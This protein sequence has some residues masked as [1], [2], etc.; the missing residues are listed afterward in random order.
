SNRRRVAVRVLHKDFDTYEDYNVLADG[1]DASAPLEV[2]LTRSER[3]LGDVLDAA[4]EPV[5]G[6]RIVIETGAP[7]PAAQGWDPAAGIE[8]FSGDDGRFTLPAPSQLR[9]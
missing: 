5:R 6:A 9:N 8:A 7:P 4:R 3:I 1:R 2:R